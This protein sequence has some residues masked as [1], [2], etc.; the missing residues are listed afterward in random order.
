MQP[1]RDA[2]VAPLYTDARPCLERG[3]RQAMHSLSLPRPTPYPSLPCGPSADPDNGLA[4]LHQKFSPPRSEQYGYPSPPMSEPQSPRRSAQNVDFERRQ[5]AA[6]ATAP[7]AGETAVSLPTPLSAHFDP[8]PL[9]PFQSTLQQRPVY[10][11]EPQFSHPSHHYQAGRSIEH[12]S[13]GGGSVPQNYTYAYPSPS[14]PSYLGAGSHVALQTQSGAMIAPSLSRPTKPARRTKAHV[15][16]ACVNCKK[17][18]LSCDI[19]RPC[20]RCVASGK[21]VSSSPNAVHRR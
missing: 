2:F 10:S 13:Y 17:A 3:H 14:T 4:K 18:H 20:G 11:G 15:A 7:P 5:Y 21:Q 1:P 8:R 16:S 19:Q 12:S 9:G 6:P